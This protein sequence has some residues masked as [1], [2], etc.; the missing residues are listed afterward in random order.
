MTS[1]IHTK[2][3]KYFGLPIICLLILALTTYV[4][5]Q[6]L[7]ETNYM[8]IRLENMYSHLYDGKLDDNSHMD[9][10]IQTKDC[11]IEATFA[12]DTYQL[13]SSCL[14]AAPFHEELAHAAVVLLLRMREKLHRS[15]IRDANLANLARKHGHR[16]EG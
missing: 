4:A 13:T 15:F 9:V 3:L 5:V 12:G 11:T 14:C 2:R 8:G 7:K 1:L 16:R 6:I 10:T